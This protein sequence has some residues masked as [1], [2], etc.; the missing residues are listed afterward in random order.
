M[1]VAK[2]RGLRGV[3]VVIVEMAEVFALALAKLAQVVVAE[4]AV[5]E[6]VYVDAIKHL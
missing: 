3:Q 5:V 2:V 4:E 6:L 1:A